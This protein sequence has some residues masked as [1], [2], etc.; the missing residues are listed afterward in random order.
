MIATI[1]CSPIH[2]AGQPHRV[3]QVDLPSLGH[4]DKTGGGHDLDLCLPGLHSVLVILVSQVI[5]DTL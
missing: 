1:Y 4:G 2:N 3:S 5:L